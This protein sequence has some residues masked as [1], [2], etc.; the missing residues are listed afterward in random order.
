MSGPARK[1]PGAAILTTDALLSHDDLP[2]EVV[3]VPEWGGAVKVRALGWSQVADARQ[4]AK[5]GGVIDDDRF[6]FG[7]LQQGMVEPALRE[8]QIEFL[9]A[10]NKIP[11]ERVLR[12]IERLSG[13]TEEV[14]AESEADF[15]Q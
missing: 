4:K 14:A 5:V 9:R 7:L 8:D 13:L 6:S 10:K 11:I 2:E 12:V 3:Q 1:D 15:P